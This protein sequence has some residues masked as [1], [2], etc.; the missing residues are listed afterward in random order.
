MPQSHSNISPSSQSYTII[1][2]IL[3]KGIKLTGPQIAG[4]DRVLDNDHILKEDTS[5][6]I[7]D[8]REVF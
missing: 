3:P 4:I 6:N 8:T 2:F 7:D 1:W 5:H